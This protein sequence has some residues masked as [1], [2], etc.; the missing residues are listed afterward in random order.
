MNGP[1]TMVAGVAWSV[2]REEVVC[3][4]QKPNKDTGTS[5][6]SISTR[7]MNKGEAVT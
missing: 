6:S 2:R 4:G 1:C 5:K 3:Y 7:E